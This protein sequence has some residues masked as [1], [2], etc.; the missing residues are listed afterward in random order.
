MHLSAWRRRLRGRLTEVT[1]CVLGR[2]NRNRRRYNVR[3]GEL[4][5]CVGAQRTSAIDSN[6]SR[7]CGLGCHHHN[8]QQRG[9]N[10]ASIW[11]RARALSMYLLVLQGGLAR[12]RRM[13][14]RGIPYRDSQRVRTC[15]IVSAPQ[16]SDSAPVFAQ[17]RRALRPGAMG[18]ANPATLWGNSSRT[19]AGDDQHRVSD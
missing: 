7:R 10:R 14:L 18:L 11:V 17:R 2:P 8:V 3:R 16:C 4:R 19:G 12:Q 6:L 1:P 9:A 13:V 15:R 5:H